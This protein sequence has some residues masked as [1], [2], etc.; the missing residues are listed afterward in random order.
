VH[1][2]RNEVLFHAT[3]RHFLVDSLQCTGDL[4]QMLDTG[5]KNLKGTDLVADSLAEFAIV[6][7][8]PVL[9]LDTGLGYVS[10]CEGVEW[11]FQHKTPFQVRSFQ[12]Q[13]HLQG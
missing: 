10:S 5:W 2:K 13:T 4:Q 1:K 8:L 11:G 6:F 3:T 12:R 7:G 9:H